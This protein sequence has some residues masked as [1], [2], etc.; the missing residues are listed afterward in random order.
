MKSQGVDAVVITCKRCAPRCCSNM[1]VAREWDDRLTAGRRQTHIRHWTTA[2]FWPSNHFSVVFPHSIHLFTLDMN[3]CL[4]WFDH[5]G[6]L[7]ARPSTPDI[8]MHLAWPLVI[9][10]H[11]LALYANGHVCI[12]VFRQSDMTDW[13]VVNVFVC[14]RQRERER[15]GVRGRE[16]AREGLTESM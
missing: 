1:S 16:W 2:V 9:A 7:W 4:R 14:V 15:K 3:T 10:S 8:K 5:S 13:S 11:F 6:Q 12:V